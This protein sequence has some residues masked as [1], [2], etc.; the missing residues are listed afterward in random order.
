MIS[1]VLC[2]ISGGVDSATSA[3]LLQKAGYGV[4]GAFMKCYSDIVPDATAPCWIEDRREALRVAAKLGIKLLSFDFEKEYRRDVI[5]YLYKEYRAGRTPNPDVMCNKY[6]KIP[7]LL[8]AAKKLGF[9]YIATGH[10]ARLRRTK[11]RAEL[12]Q[13]ADENKDQ[14]YFLHQ[15]GQKELSRLIFP[16]GALRKDEVRVLAKQFDLPVADREESMGICFVGETPMKEFLQKKIKTRRGLVIFRGKKIGEHEGLAFYTIGERYGGLARQARKEGATQLFVVDKH[17]KNNQLVI[18][19]ADDS[20]L[21]KKKIQVS[22]VNWLAGQPPVFPLKCE[23]RLRHRQP[24]Q[25]AIIKCIG[26]KIEVN[27]EKPQRAVTPG[28]FA[29]FYR[30]N[31]CLGGGTIA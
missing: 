8:K 28:Q 26:K 17:S 14:T 21:F 30:G 16:I 10:Y 22:K 12:F 13:A 29:V 11:D 15:L 5:D 6:V 1:K 25:K 24:L 19:S 2:A 4:T 23:V 20:L 31:E 18:G 27:F 9:D 7:L 3:A